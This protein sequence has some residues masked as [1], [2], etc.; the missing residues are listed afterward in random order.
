MILYQICS[1]NF[2][3]YDFFKLKNKLTVLFYVQSLEQSFLNPGT[4]GWKRNF[5]LLAMLLPCRTSSVDLLAPNEKTFSLNDNDILWQTL[6]IIVV[7]ILSH[8]P[9]SEVAWNSPVILHLLF[10]AQAFKFHFIRNANL[11][12][13][14]LLCLNSRARIGLDEIMRLNE[15]FL[16]PALQVI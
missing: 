14:A 7:L 9:Q 16:I 13:I 15:E 3:V 10:E 1:N 8:L 12:T 6:L 4:L 2:C 11:P 5:C